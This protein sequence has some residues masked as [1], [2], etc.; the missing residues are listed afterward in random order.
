VTDAERL[1]WACEV[2]NRERHNCNLWRIV[3]QWGKPVVQRG[4][5]DRLTAFDSAAI[6]LALDEQARRRLAPV[7][8]AE[9]AA[10]QLSRLGH[11][12]KLWAVSVR[13]GG[14]VVVAQDGEAMPWPDALAIAES[15]I[16]REMLGDTS[17]ANSKGV[18]P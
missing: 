1:E 14:T 5:G 15:L 6:A 11:H 9:W 16:R 4:N 17:D 13:S 8:R 3:S 2:L 7:D 12:E 18:K 10:L